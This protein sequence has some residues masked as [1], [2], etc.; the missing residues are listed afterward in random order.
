MATT[1]VSGELL[2]LLETIKDECDASADACN[3]DPATA[4]VSNDFEFIGDM[5]RKALVMLRS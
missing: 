2:E 1:T 5:V 3:E 4:D